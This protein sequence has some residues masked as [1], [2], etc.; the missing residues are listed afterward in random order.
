LLQRS[1]LFIEKEYKSLSPALSKGEG[2]IQA[3]DEFCSRG[4]YCS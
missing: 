4:A 1:I 3:K 2:A